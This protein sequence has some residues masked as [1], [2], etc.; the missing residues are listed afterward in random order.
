MMPG[1]YTYDDVSPICN[2][3]DQIMNHPVLG[4]LIATKHK[5]LV[6]ALDAAGSSLKI[7]LLLLLL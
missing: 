1:E 7:F 5:K 4:D 3:S 2:Y 6:D